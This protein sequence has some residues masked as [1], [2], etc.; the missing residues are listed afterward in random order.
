[1]PP[2]E[3]LHILEVGMLA[4]LFPSLSKLEDQL[5]RT[6]VHLASQPAAK[7]VEMDPEE[8]LELVIELVA[9]RVAVSSPF[10]SRSGA[11]C[12]ERPRASA[13]QQPAGHGFLQM[14]A[15]GGL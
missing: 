3:R 9:A 11:I 14:N 7:T 6:L 12:V 10:S 8:A 1:M 2:E 15:L 5:P 13:C 4:N